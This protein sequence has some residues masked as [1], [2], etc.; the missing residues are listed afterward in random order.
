M[1]APISNLHEA[2]PARLGKGLSAIFA[3]SD[4]IR[5][6]PSAKL[7]TLPI[8]QLAPSALQPR[9]NFDKEQ[10]QELA[11]SI[12]EKGLLQPILVRPHAGKPNTYE[13]IAGERR[14]RAAQLV[15]LHEVPVIVRDIKD[16]EALEV[17]LIENVQ[18]ADLS[19]MEEAESY[20]RLIDEFAHKAEA[21]ADALGKS[22][23]Y[24]S[25]MLRLNGLPKEVK[26]LLRAG[27]LTA[28]HARAVLTSKNPLAL[29][30]EVVKGGLSVRQTENLAKL[31]HGET[32]EKRGFDRAPRKGSA[33]AKLAAVK[34]ADVLKLE[35][36]VSA[37]LGLKVKLTPRGK[38]GLLSIEYA[39]LD[40]LE[41]VLA[42]LA[43]PIKMAG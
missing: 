39:S 13:I 37:W 15:N 6:D 16:K 32:Q 10:L 1:A 23:A 12:T 5:P 43:R 38:G 25:N 19:P 11:A 40:Q 33:K 26:D 18:R 22:R 14:W 28:G 2:K 3:D 29:A 20:Q 21:L 4:P 35:R 30:Q 24:V 17:A 41:D 42:R 8:E 7:R 27:A 9:K 31:S 34:D 36:E